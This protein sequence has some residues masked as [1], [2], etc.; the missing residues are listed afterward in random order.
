MA[1]TQRQNNVTRRFYKKIIF[2]LSFQVPLNNNR[3]FPTSRYCEFDQNIP[4]NR[5]KR[6]T[7]CL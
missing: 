4:Q 7:N 1:K 3:T 5:E 2:I 6:K